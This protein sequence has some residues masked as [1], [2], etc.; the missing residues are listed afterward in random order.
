MDETKNGNFEDRKRSYINHI[1]HI[2][3]IPNPDQTQY[4]NYSHS[5]AWSFTKEKKC[6]SYII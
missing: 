1:S 2:Q 6:K 5:V 3:N 4:M